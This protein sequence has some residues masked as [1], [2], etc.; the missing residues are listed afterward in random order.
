SIR[1]KVPTVILV[2]GL[3]VKLPPGA[4]P[5][6]GDVLEVAWRKSENQLALA[7]PHSQIVIARKSG[8]YIQCDEPA[9]VVQAIHRVIGEA[10]RRKE[11][12]FVDP[13]RFSVAANSTSRKVSSPYQHVIKGRPFGVG[14]EC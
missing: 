4:P 13:I 10:P 14:F 12:R 3:P 9:L 7:V 11:N 2:R 6:F 5:K 8:H 1:K